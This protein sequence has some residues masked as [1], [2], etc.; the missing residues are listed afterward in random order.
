MRLLHEAAFHDVS[1]DDIPLED[2]ELPIS[3]MDY[4]SSVLKAQFDVN[5]GCLPPSSLY[6]LQ[7]A[8]RSL[9]RRLV[10]P[11]GVPCVQIHFVASHYVVSAQHNDTVTVYDSLSNRGRIDQVRAQLRMLYATLQRDNG[12]AVRYVTSQSQQ[13]TQMCG[14][15]A[16]ANAV[17]LLSNKKVTQ[18]VFR[19]MEMRKHL[20]GCLATGHIS[21]FPE[22][23]MT[24]AHRER[25]G[26]QSKGNG[27]KMDVGGAPD[28]IAQYLQSQSALASV[29]LM[30]KIM[31]KLQ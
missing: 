7:V 6:S 13:N 1:V 15:F 21:M 10:V 19:M 3:V 4:V 28:W 11:L 5:H 24:A 2:A 26:I 12:P 31:E 25:S 27:E 20:R 18:H 16:T 8:G 17:L 29:K 23:P 30:H 22:I 9:D 14:L